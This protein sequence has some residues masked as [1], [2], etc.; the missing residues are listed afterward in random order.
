M[1]SV[2][3]LFGLFV[4]VAAGY[5]ALMLIPPYFSNYQL[6][7][8]IGSIAKFAGPTD[9]SEESIRTEVMKKVK[10]YDLPIKPEQIK[11]TRE[12]RLIVI[13]IDYTN[14]VELVGGKRVVLVFHD[15]SK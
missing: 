12:D 15:S 9:R 2:K 1:R 13:N 6:R 3:A 8:D 4:V 14:T 7:D 10:E 11:I 5:L